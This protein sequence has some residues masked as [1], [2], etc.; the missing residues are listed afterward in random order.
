MEDV[1]DAHETE[2]AA[3]GG[4]GVCSRCGERAV[5]ED[6]IFGSCVC[7]NCGNVE[8]EVTLRHQPET[9]ASQ[10]VRAEKPLK[11]LFSAIPAGAYGLRLARAEHSE[12]R[13][14][15]VKALTR[16]ATSMRLPQHIAEQSRECLRRVLEDE[17]LKRCR[18][19][20][21]AA[22]CIYYVCRR[23][24]RPLTLD[25]LAQSQ[26]LRMRE[27][28]GLFRKVSA[29]LKTLAPALPPPKPKVFVQNICDKLK[30]T[31]PVPDTARKI[32]KFAKTAWLD[33]GR[34]PLP[35]AMAAVLIAMEV[36]G[37][38]P[39]KAEAEKACEE[40]GV[41]YSTVK[42]RL[43]EIRASLT[44]SA[45]SLP[46]SN[47]LTKDN[48]AVFVPYVLQHMTKNGKGKAEKPLAQVASYTP[49]AFR[50]SQQAREARQKKLMAAK[51]R[52]RRTIKFYPNLAQKVRPDVLVKLENADETITPASSSSSDQHIAVADHL[53]LV[54]PLDNEDIMIE[55]LLLVGVS[56]AEILDG[57][58]DTARQLSA[59]EK[60]IPLDSENLTEA[61]IPEAE[62]GKFIRRP[63]EIRTLD[64]DRPVKKQRMPAEEGSAAPPPP[65]PPP[66]AAAGVSA[67][68][69]HDIDDDDEQKQPAAVA[70]V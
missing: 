38:K 27:V 50:V 32:I 11:V 10:T 42:D 19:E 34:A 56:D 44:A 39:K 69:A 4:V 52:L 64:D 49:P 22:S 62:L 35:I 14:G 54:T 48:L 1:E 26:G 16:M 68:S 61:D 40:C 12:D 17:A 18:C 67:S 33:S 24:Q 21:L 25:Q 37:K 9:E 47:T 66:P 29:K 7:T 15:S 3:L 13:L 45:A 59:K 41:K 65:P 6:P 51:A 23:E 20:I 8:D 55:R 53:A 5:A 58:Y 46:W 63:E 30:L 57:Y 60:S 28:A 31:H 2:G 43:S 70:G 36:G